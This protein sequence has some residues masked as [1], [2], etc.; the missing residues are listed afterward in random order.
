[1]DG[2]GSSQICLTF[3]NANDKIKQNSLFLA[4]LV[5]YISDKLTPLCEI[6]ID[7]RPVPFILH[8]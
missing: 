6:K 3:I 8:Y 5:E 2:Q 7:E 4:G 1:V